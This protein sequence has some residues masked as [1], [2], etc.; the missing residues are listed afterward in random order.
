MAQTAINKAVILARGLGT[1]MRRS[2]QGVQL[3]ARQAAV[4]ETGVK[5]LIPLDRPFLDYL[6][7]ALADAGYR[8]ICLVVAPQHELLRDYLQR[9]SPPRRVSVDFA[10]QQEPRGTA[11]AVAAAE[12]FAGAD[13]FLVINSDNYYPVEAL[14]RLREQPGC[15]VALF[16]QEAMLAGSNIAPE[17][18]GQFAVG[19]I[20]ERGLLRRVLEKPDAA[21]L[22]SLPRPL[23]LSMNCWRFT[24]AIFDACHNISP[25][26][27]GELEITD[28]VQ[29]AI[30]VR[31]EPFVAVKIRAPVLDMTSRAD[32]TDMAARLRGVEV[33]P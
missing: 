23:W 30:D 17:R 32:I 2:D 26:A 8:W 12:A 27:R 7:S 13:P 21:T 1:R 29:Y 22:A 6:L 24:P 5:A 14:E 18:L 16:E 31:E 28:A 4:A 15:A 9:Q 25:S 19:K 33:D 3:D 20:D 10:V 11:D